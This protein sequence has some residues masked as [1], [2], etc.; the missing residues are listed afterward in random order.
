MRNSA[1]GNYEAGRHAGRQA[2]RQTNKPRHEAH[3]EKNSY[4]ILD[5]SIHG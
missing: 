1:E 2:G 3:G 5:T 4:V